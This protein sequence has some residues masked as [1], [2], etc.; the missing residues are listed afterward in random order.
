MSVLYF[1]LLVGVLV[2]IHEL[3]H[4]V[5]AKLLDVKV[6][7]FSIGYGRALFRVTLGETEYQI[8]AFPLGGYV[9]ILGI[10]GPP[11]DPGGKGEAGRSF[12]SRPLW[13]RLVIVFA[14]PAANLVLPVI[15]YFVF[16]AGHT[17]LPAAVVGDVLDGG[18]AAR[19][20]IEPGDRVLEINGRAIRYWEEIE[21]SVRSSPGEE[22][23]LRIHR[24]GK[25]FERY[26]TPIEDTVRSRDGGVKV[27]GRVGI[28]HAPFVPLVGVIDGQSPA[29]R[30][31]LRTGDLIISVDGQAVRNW[32]DVQHQLGKFARRTSIVYFRG[33][34]LAGVPQVELLAAGFADLVPETQIDDKLRRQ[35]YTGLE[36]AEMFVKHVDAGSPADGAGL[37]PGDLIV[38]LDG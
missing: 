20:G 5:A 3:G 31:G 25:T 32:R 13:Q 16:F 2:L 17:V 11:D 9:R 10:E 19:A 33:T 12:A 28:T 22:L 6:L 14:G 36:H 15:I 35:T 24:N 1:L 23:H 21:E 7:R 37:R 18:A 27:Q 34:E 29:A 8:A 4:F 38:S 26:L 30:A